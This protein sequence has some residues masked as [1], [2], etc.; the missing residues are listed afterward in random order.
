M[1]VCNDMSDNTTLHL[2]AALLL[3]WSYSFQQGSKFFFSN[4]KYHNW[5]YARLIKYHAVNLILSDVLTLPSYCWQSQ[6]TCW[7]MD[8]Y[9]RMWFCASSFVRTFAVWCMEIL[10]SAVSGWHNHVSLEVLPQITGFIRLWQI[11]LYFPPQAKCAFV[12][13]LCF[14]AFILV[15]DKL[16]M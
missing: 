13:C 1:T 12:Q 5:L 3:F 10:S 8:L 7:M 4:S 2:I 14:L 16:W 9:H 11:N 15:L 6:N